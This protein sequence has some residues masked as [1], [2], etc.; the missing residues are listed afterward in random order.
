MQL[1]VILQLW[2]I[3]HFKIVRYSVENRKKYCFASI[4]PTYYPE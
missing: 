1:L 2:M 4:D 3:D